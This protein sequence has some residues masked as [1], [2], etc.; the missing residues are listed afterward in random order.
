MTREEVIGRTEAN[1]SMFWNFIPYPSRA[2]IGRDQL[3]YAIFK[4]MGIVE[5][6]SKLSLS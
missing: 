3:L 2:C 5:I 4:I 1:V 6:G